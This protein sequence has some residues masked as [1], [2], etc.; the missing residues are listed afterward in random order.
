MTDSPLRHDITNEKFEVI[1]GHISIPEGPG[2]GFT[3]NQL[4]IEKYR[5]A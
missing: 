5:V 3:I 4:T 2:L 1:D